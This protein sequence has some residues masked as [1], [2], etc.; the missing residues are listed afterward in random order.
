MAKSSKPSKSS[1]SKS[2][3]SKSSRS[4]KAKGDE[5]QLRKAMIEYFTRE[6]RPFNNTNLVDGLAGM[7]TRTA[8]VKMMDVLADEGVLTKKMYKK[9]KIYVISQ[10]NLPQLS[11]EE[12]AEVDASIAELQAEVED[13]DSALVNLAGRNKALEAMPTNEA[14]QAEL[15]ALREEYASKSAKLEKLELSDREML[16]R[17]DLNKLANVY[18][19]A[20]K[21][22]KKRKRIIKD[23]VDLLAENSGKK[24]AALLELMGVETDEEVGVDIKA[25]PVPEPPKKKRKLLGR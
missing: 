2:S 7:F 3:R 14:L 20:H 16:S 18:A 6:N 12:L 21:T 23:C 19:E 1:K 10:D 25:M 11:E 4:S 8:V 17:D 9:Q 13:L 22:W 15:S 24:P 5:G